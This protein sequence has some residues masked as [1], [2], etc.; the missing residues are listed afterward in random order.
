M[1]TPKIK[2]KGY[3]LCASPNFFILQ[4]SFTVYSTLTKITT[5]N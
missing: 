5:Y 3:L 1:H 2:A 4:A